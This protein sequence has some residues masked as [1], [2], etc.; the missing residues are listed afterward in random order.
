MDNFKLHY[1]FSQ[2]WLDRKDIDLGLSGVL[3]EVYVLIIS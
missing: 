2:L 3:I 1:D